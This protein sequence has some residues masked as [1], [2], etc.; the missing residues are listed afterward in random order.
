MFVADIF[1]S[2]SENAIRLCESSLQMQHYSSSKTAYYVNMASA[3]AN[4]SK[5][6][7]RKSVFRG[8]GRFAVPLLLSLR[9]PYLAFPSAPEGLPALEGQ[10]DAKG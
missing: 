9:D 2:D 1:L 5:A 3:F 4:T 10:I 7:L 8:P 6:G